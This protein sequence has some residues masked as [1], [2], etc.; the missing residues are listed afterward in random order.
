MDIRQSRARQAAIATLAALAL[1]PLDSPAAVYYLRAQATTLALPGGASVPMWGYASCDAAFTTCGPASVPG[2]AL[3]VPPGEGLAVH[4]RNELPV[5]TSL[6]IHGQAVAMT[7]VWNDGS[8]GARPSA[9]ARVRSFTHEAAAGGGTAVY[10]WPALRPGTYLY[11]SGT[12]PQVQVQMGLYGAAVK[13]FAAGLAYPGVAYDQDVLVVYSE[14]DPALHEAV[15]GPTPTYGTPAGP[16]STL[17]YVPR[18]FLVNGKAHEPG[19]PALATIAV[20]DT[21]LLRLVNAGLA[22][23][24]PTL[25]GEYLRIVA[26]D[27]NLA[28]WPAHPRQ[29]WSVF[30]PAAKTVDATLAPAPGGASR[31]ALYDRAMGLTNDRA[32]DG[33]ML[34]FLDVADAGSPPAITSM[35]PL[36]ATQGQP[37]AYAATASDPDG[38]TLTWSLD[39]APAGMA[40]DAASGLV[41]W[42]PSIAQLGPNPV[43]LRVTDPTARFATQSF[44]ITVAA[45]PA[46]QPPAITSTPPLA[47]T[48]GVAYAYAATATDPEGGMLTW[49]LD[50]APA[51]MAIDAATGMVA[52]T[53][54]KSQVGTADV[55]VRVTDPTTLFATQPFSIAVADANYAPSASADGYGMVQGGALAVAA[56]GVLG[57]DADPDGDAMTA[58][59]V[60]G[61]V[62]GM[63]ALAADGAFSYTPPATIPASGPA[64]TRTFTYTASDPLGHASAPATVT[65]TIAANAAP[66]AVEDTF[67]APRRTGAP[68]TA[69]VLAVLANDYD[70]DSAA[71][72]SNAIDPSTVTIPASGQPNRGGTATVNADG[73]VSYSPARN[74]R[75][76]ENFTYHVRDTRGAL[77][78]AGLVRVNVR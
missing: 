69:I 72:P 56:P 51:G 61:P 35:P 49:S 67:A 65:I 52:W 32:P 19:D 25:D 57:N 23:R 30:L 20:G 16:T 34:A 76:T 4:L 11:Q 9:A 60:D 27:G 33:G 78:A 15:A 70:P 42:T 45:D 31:L 38:G 41:A 12:H 18:Y 24:V 22:S 26:E 74:F 3:V 10:E 21:T 62:D 39:A 50:A 64:A 77:S 36:A 58:T 68:Y 1:G 71:D 13:D 63:L 55:V 48:Y 17:D 73:T 44:A 5:P 6:V 43:T 46:A 28:P 75:G 7:P 14:I 37:Y 59:L 40:V 53:P 2:P 66:V 8:A 54:L 47:A 29:R